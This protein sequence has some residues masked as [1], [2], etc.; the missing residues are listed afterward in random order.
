MLIVGKKVNDKLGRK[1]GFPFNLGDFSS[2]KHGTSLVMVRF[3]KGVH[4]EGTVRPYHDTMPGFMYL[5]HI[6]HCSIVDNPVNDAFVVDYC[7]TFP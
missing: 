2:R 5:K 1:L 7:H 3:M 6:F 4:G